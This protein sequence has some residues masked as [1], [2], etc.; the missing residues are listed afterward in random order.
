MVMSTTG[1]KKDEVED[2]PE[3]SPDHPFYKRGFVVG[4]TTS[5]PSSKSTQGQTSDSESKKQLDAPSGNQEDPMQAGRS[6]RAPM[7]DA[8]E[9]IERSILKLRRESTESTTSKDK[10]KA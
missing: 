7:Q 8:A 9:A 4:R 5:T 6:T 10:D 2:F 1:K 3:L